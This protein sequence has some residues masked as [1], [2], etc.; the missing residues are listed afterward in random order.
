[1][2]HLCTFQLFARTL[3]YYIIYVMNAGSVRTGC[4]CVAGDG[5]GHVLMDSVQKWCG[6]WVE[7][8]LHGC[9][10]ARQSVNPS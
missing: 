1:M 8:A 6:R 3:V 5:G 9:I 2:M 10:F 4:R 7:V